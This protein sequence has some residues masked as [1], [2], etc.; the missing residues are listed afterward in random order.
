MIMDVCLN[1]GDDR[2]AACSGIETRRCHTLR[3]SKSDDSFKS[4]SGEL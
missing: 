4:Q 3:Y 1:E 2:A